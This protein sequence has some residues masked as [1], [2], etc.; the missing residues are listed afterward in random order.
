MPNN[1]EPTSVG[2]APAKPKKKKNFWHKIGDVFYKIGDG[3]ANT[4]AQSTDLG[5]DS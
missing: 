2:G 1:V 5:G 4:I 3:V